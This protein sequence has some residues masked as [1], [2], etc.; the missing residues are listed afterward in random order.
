MTRICFFSCKD[1]WQL[2]STVNLEL[3]NVSNWFRANK[4]SLNTKKTNFILFGNKRIPDTVEKFSVSID[5]YLL[6]QVE[7]TKF[8]RIFVDAKLNW[9]KHIEYIAMKIS[10]GLA[11]LG[12][13]G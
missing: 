10:K 1:I 4:L 2:M 8:L 3:M 7:H 12:R 11:A 5:G 6:E 13:V 9:K